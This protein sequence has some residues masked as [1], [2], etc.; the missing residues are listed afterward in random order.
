MYVYKTVV[1]VYIKIFVL[2][3]TLHIHLLINILR[4][5]SIN[6]YIDNEGMS[7]CCLTRERGYKYLW[8]EQTFRLFIILTTV[9]SRKT[10]K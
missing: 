3:I 9:I 7:E 2:L 8:A 5:L 10:N 6:A 4:H 1:R